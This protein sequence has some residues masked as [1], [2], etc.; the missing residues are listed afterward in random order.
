MDLVHVRQHGGLRRPPE[1]RHRVAHPV[2]P[3]RPKARPALPGRTATPA[4]TTADALCFRLSP[5]T[6]ATWASSG[7]LALA[8]TLGVLWR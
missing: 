3:V 5:K 8:V 6:L 1:P 7:L 2:P 4:T